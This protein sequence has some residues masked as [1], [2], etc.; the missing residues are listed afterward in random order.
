[1]S[2]SIADPP[3]PP[4]TPTRLLTEEEQKELDE[5]CNDWARRANAYHFPPKPAESEKTPELKKTPEN[6]ENS[7]NPQPPKPSSPCVV[8]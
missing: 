3:L 2:L 5:E 8:Q 4:K 7:P 1:M 6:T